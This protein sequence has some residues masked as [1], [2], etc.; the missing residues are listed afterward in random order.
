MRGSSSPDQKRAV[1]CRRRSIRETGRPACKDQH[2]D[3]TGYLHLMCTQL[4]VGD[5]TGFVIYWWK[6]KGRGNDE[7]Y[8]ETAINGHGLNR[9]NLSASFPE[10]VLR[11]EIHETSDLK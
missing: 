8:R 9:D 5:G 2:E 6:K 11:L 7:T 3:N 4:E 1:T 10:P